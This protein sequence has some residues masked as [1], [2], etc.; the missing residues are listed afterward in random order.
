MELASFLILASRRDLYMVSFRRIETNHQRKQPS[1]LGKGL[2]EGRFSSFLRDH[3][4]QARSFS[5]IFWVVPSVTISLRRR[6][7][8]LIDL[9]IPGYL[10][11]AAL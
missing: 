8:P 9:N 3:A 5:G 4:G 7:G 1:R 2:G 6:V 10:S 11:S